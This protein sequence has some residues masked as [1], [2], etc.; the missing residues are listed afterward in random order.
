MVSNLFDIN[1]WC[2]AENAPKDLRHTPK[3][4][5]RCQYCGL[6]NP[7]WKT[8]T[9]ST[10]S[11]KVESDD[12]SDIEILPSMP[13]RPQATQ[14]L[15]QLPSGTSKPSEAVMTKIPPYLEGAGT[16]AR[17]ESISRNPTTRKKVPAIPPSVDLIVGIHRY[18]D[19]KSVV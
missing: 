11:V 12:N 4:G 5:K 13:E 18:R 19:R 2:L 17:Q 10:T 3:L 8:L 15:S 9:P 1:T 14:L 7:E 6:W 16:V